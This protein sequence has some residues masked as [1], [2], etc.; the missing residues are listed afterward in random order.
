VAAHYGYPELIE[1]IRR[2]LY[3]QVNPNAEIPGDRID[4]HRCPSFESDIKVFNSA[5]ATYYAPSD[6]SGRGGMHRNLIRCTP[7]WRGGSARYDCVFVDN[8]GSNDDPLCG[9]LVARVLLFFSFRFQGRSHSCALVEWFLPSGYEPDPSTGMW[10]VVPEVNTTGHRVRAVISVKSI[11]RGVHL[12]GV[13]GA[14]FLPVTF[15][16]SD[17]LN[18]F[19]AYYVNRYIDHHSYTIC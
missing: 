16:F 4:L 15:H 18:A 1:C 11:L 17:S 10:I 5:S 2:Y 3:D 9:L 14:A 12:I 7:R 19:N 6:H 8:G 13:Y